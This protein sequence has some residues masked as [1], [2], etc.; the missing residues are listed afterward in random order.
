MKHLK[1]FWKWP[2]LEEK[3]DI[4][5]FNLAFNNKHREKKNSS[6]NKEN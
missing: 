6:K 2:F 3:N 4:Y 5:E 1:Q